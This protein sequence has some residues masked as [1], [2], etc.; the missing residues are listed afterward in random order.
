MFDQEEASSIGIVREL[1]ANESLRNDLIYIAANFSSLVNSNHSILRLE[2]RD[3]SLPDALEVFEMTMKKI[4]I[5]YGKVGASVKRKSE[6]V[7]VNNPGFETIMKI[8]DI[9]VGKREVQIEKKHAQAATYLK[10]A[11]TTSV[12]VERSFSKLKIILSDRR[13]C[14]TVENLKKMLIVACNNL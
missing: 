5:A 13:L 10:F 2:K 7:V 3:L 9:I 14:L 6:R 12:E 4:D 1:M 8:K 11:P